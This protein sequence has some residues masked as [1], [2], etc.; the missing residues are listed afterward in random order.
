MLT[1]PEFNV[2]HLMDATITVELQYTCQ[3]WHK[4]LKLPLTQNR[5]WARKE[6]I[7][8][9]LDN[10]TCETNKLNKYLL[11]R[12]FVYLGGGNIS[13]YVNLAKDRLTLT[14]EDL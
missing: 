5:K 3:W 1:V 10:L 4:N 9:L 8:D 2:L 7:L 6:V 13:G 14:M 12:L 11:L